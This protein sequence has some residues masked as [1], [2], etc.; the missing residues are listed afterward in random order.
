MQIEL[1]FADLSHALHGSFDWLNESSWLCRP[2]IENNFLRW[3]D[4]KAVE[5]V[6]EEGFFLFILSM[7]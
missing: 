2:A 1:V 4:C 7:I 5:R 3:R 6:W